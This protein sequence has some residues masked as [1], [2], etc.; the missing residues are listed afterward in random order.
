M[1]QEIL[2]EINGVAIANG[3]P[4]GIEQLG[5]DF[6]EQLSDNLRILSCDQVEQYTVQTITMH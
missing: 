5:A 2:D 6:P 4:D 3:F 1:S